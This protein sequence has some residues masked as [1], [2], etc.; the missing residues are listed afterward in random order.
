LLFL[1]FLNKIAIDARMTS[2]GPE[3]EKLAADST[4][5]RHSR[6]PA[7]FVLHDPEVHVEINR[8]SVENSTPTF[9]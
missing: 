2:R 6:S 4:E 7:A 3:S 9:E 5:E 1:K 8:L